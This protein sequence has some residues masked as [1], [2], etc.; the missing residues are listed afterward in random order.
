MCAR[1]L[2][3]D[4]ADPSRCSCVR[5]QFR[6]VP[7][8]P[9]LRIRLCRCRSRHSPRSSRS[10]IPAAASK[11]RKSRATA[12]MCTS[13][14]MAASSRTATVPRYGRLRKSRRAW[15][16][17][18]R[19]SSSMSAIT[20]IARARVPRATEAAREARMATI[21]GAGKRTSSRRPRRRCAR[22][23]GSSCAA[24]TRS[25]A[26]PVVVIFACSTQDRHRPDRR[27]ASI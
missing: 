18:S 23:H 10:A 4:P 12:R 27:H 14:T 21:G 6:R 15:P 26:A 13:T 11:P 20:S 5:C 1:C 19:T 25:A 8:R 24:I 22:R 2:T 7:G 17:P 16:L 3:G 9:A